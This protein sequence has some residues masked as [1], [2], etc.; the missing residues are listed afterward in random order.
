ML[1]LPIKCKV[2]FPYEQLGSEPKKIILKQM[3]IDLIKMYLEFIGT[4]FLLQY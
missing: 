2:I 4:L 3:L 1:K